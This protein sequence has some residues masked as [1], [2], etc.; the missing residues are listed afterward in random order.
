MDTETVRRSVRERYGKL[1]S[2]K[3]S[4]GC[5][6]GS[7]GCCSTTSGNIASTLGYTKEDTDFVPDGSNL[8]LGCGNPRAIAALKSGETVLDLGS[9]AGFDC[10]LA[11]KQ[12]GANG[13]VIGVDMTPEMVAKARENAGKTGNSA[14]SNVDFRLGEIEHLPVADESVDVIISNCVI[15]LSGE[16]KKVFQEAHRVLKPGGR[17]AIVDILAVTPLPES[18]RNDPGAISSCIGGAETIEALSRL[19]EATGFVNIRITPVPESRQAI[20]QWLPEMKAGISVQSAAVE[21]VKRQD[22]PRTVALTGEKKGR[23]DSEE[24]QA[25]VVRGFKSGQHCAETVS[26]TILGIFSLQ[27]YGPAVHCAAGF[28][29]GIGGTFEEVCG[30]LSGGVLALGSLLGRDV[31]N[32][33]HQALGKLTKQFRQRFL[34]EFGST[35]CR[36]LRMGFGERNACRGCAKLSARAA[37]ILADLLYSFEGDTGIAIETWTREHPE[38]ASEDGHPLS[39]GRR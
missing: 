11:A 39:A 29:G 21:A 10:F 20:N 33:N 36:T 14:F 34:A 1:A 17:L 19:L 7:A 27:P 22:N 37:G 26:Q 5:A 9:G 2:M 3:S 32:F 12:V 15:N 25:R 30:A 31:P 4:G 38:D 8:G 23:I 16:K 24:I 18:I 13:R 6:C 28:G 35:N